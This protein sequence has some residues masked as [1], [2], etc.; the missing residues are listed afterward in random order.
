[1]RNELPETP[2]LRLERGILVS[3][4]TQIASMNAGSG[5][6]LVQSNTLFSPYRWAIV[7]FCISLRISW[8][9]RRWNGG[10][11]ERWNVGTGERWN[12]GALER[13]NVEALKRWSVEVVEWFEYG[14]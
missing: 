5:R 8:A 1:M 12:G 7:V 4:A 2:F 11:L 9:L 10:A 14:A 3:N 13:W 6:F